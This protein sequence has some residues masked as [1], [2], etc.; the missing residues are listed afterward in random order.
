MIK[1]AKKLIALV[2]LFILLSG[3]ACAEPTYTMLDKLVY[4]L[5]AGSG[6]RGEFTLNGKELSFSYLDSHGIT[7][8]VTEWDGAQLVLYHQDGKLYLITENEQTFLDVNHD[9]LFSE[10]LDDAELPGIPGFVAGLYPRVWHDTILNDWLT[11][12]ETSLDM[13]LSDYLC[14][15]D[16]EKTQ[17]GDTLL[18]TRYA[19]PAV[20]FA[21]KMGEMLT[22]FAQNP[23]L[24]SLLK[25]LMSVEEAAKFADASRY[26]AYIA[27]ITGLEWDSDLEIS[28]SY[29][30]RTGESQST[31]SLPLAIEG[32]P[33]QR[34]E[35]T[36]CSNGFS[37]DLNGD[38]Y[39]ASFDI[40]TDESTSSFIGTASQHRDGSD[41]DTA[42]SGMLLKD[43]NVQDDISR[44]GYT[45]LLS[46]TD[47][48]TGEPM[49]D[50]S[51]E[52]AF[53]S[54]SA[55]N[56][57]TLVE[58][59]ISLRTSENSFSLRGIAQTTAPWNMAI[60]DSSSAIPLEGNIISALLD[61]IP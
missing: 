34:A 56:V 54:G 51:A 15:N 14:W 1:T 58:L 4:Q 50:L 44:H 47:A 13:W 7:Q 18:L 5:E 61:V 49:A 52:A 32:V 2:L 42:F 40:A 12:T 30:M 33:Y 36:I 60:L 31:L 9:S 35:I 26:P 21:R 24:L 48:A 6:L 3:N 43:E 45:L 46:V 53:R 16:T 11:N 55:K 39:T 8:I 59:D 37:V 10:V 19:V 20:D 28:S 27:L 38:G 25:P 23:S 22:D 57:S 29:S 17:D 41:T